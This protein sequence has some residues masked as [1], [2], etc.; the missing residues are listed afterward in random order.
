MRRFTSA[1]RRTGENIPL[2]CLKAAGIQSLA[3][4]AYCSL[5]GLMS[6]LTKRTLIVGVIYTVVIEGVLANLPFSIRLATVIYYT[7]VIAYRTLE[8]I[9]TSPRGGTENIAAEAWQF[10]VR[11]DP[12]LLA[13][14]QVTTCIAVLLVSSLVFTA[15]AAVICSR[16][17]F[18][19][20][21]PE[22][23]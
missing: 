12:D 9:V 4:I 1:R 17:E 22:V 20:K 16:R 5:F 18:H 6:L 11:R 7:R 15:I 13:H 21:V 2:R 3:V 23:N 19:V 14:P 10:D 8:F